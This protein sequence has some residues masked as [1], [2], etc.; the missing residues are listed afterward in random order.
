MSTQTTA[1]CLIA[2]SKYAGKYAKQGG[3]TYTYSI[4]GVA[5]KTVT[6]NK[7]LAQYNIGIKNKDNGKIKVTNSGQGILYA[8]IVLEGV[9]LT[10]Q[11][12]SFENNLIMNVTYKTLD[13]KTIDPTRLEQ[14][15][16]FM[17]EVVIRNPDPVQLYKDMALSQIFP[18]GW[19]IHNTRMD[20]FENV[21]TAD[22]P[23]YEDIRDDR[24][25]SYFNVWPQK[26]VTFRVLLN[27][28]YQGEYYLS[29]PFCEAMY[30]NSVSSSKSGKWVKVVKAGEL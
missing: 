28:A 29:G 3:F 23:D 9:P 10:G 20:G 11:E 19:E 17:A 22:K 30:D 26:Q 14:G 4:N 8:R 18:S 13:G 2:V 5:P 12:K 16:D 27:A 1:Y 24:V 25:Y 6:G 15:T 21:H 7:P